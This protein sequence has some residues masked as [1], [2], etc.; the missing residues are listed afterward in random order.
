VQPFPRIRQIIERPAQIAALQVEE[1]FEAKP[2]YEGTVRGSNRREADDWYR[3]IAF[4]SVLD[5]NFGAIS[6]WAEVISR[7]LRQ[8][9]F[10]AAKRR[11]ADCPGRV[12]DLHCRRP[13][14]A[15]RG[16]QF[17]GGAVDAAPDLLFSD[18]EEALDQ[19]GPGTRSLSG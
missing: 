10:M 18:V 4:A 16:F 6:V 19:I 5:S 8:K 13:C 11:S 12:L 17:R 1:T 9:R 2:L 14:S 15:D 7:V 3:A